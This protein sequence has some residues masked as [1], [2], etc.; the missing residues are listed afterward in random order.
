EASPTQRLVG[1]FGGSTIG[2]IFAVWGAIFVAG[3]IGWAFLAAH[4]PRR[5]VLTLSLLGM[6]GVVGT[7]AAFNHGAPAAVLV[8]ATA[9][10]LV[11]C[12]FT[13]AALAQLGDLTAGRDE[14]RGAAMGLYSLLLGTGQLLGNLLG[15]P[16]A[17]RWAMDGVLALT[18]AFALVALACVRGMGIPGRAREAN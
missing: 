14:S 10:V 16:L 11:E 13:P 18:G 1:G 15:G 4:W 12:G 17:A 5:R 7:L 9:F 2:T 8:A 3:T 6:L